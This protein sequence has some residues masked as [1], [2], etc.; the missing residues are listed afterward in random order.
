MT[1]YEASSMSEVMKF[2]A[3][4]CLRM[5]IAGPGVMISRQNNSPRQPQQQNGNQGSG[6]P[7]NQQPTQ[8]QNQQGFFNPPQSQQPTPNVAANKVANDFAGFLNANDDLPF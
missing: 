3:N 6:G 8:P 1:P 5:E 2:F 7:F 4:E